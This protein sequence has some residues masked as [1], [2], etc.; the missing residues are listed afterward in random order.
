MGIVNTHVTLPLMSMQ[1]DPTILVIDT[2]KYYTRL[3]T[4][5]FAHG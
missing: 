5:V 1:D 3:H 4:T 2:D